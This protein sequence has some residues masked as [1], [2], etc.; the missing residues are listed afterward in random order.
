[1]KHR[2]YLPAVLITVLLLGGCAFP[3]KHAI[4][5]EAAAAVEAGDYAGALELLE[6]AEKAG[7][8]EQLLHRARALADMG[9]ADYDGAVDEF[10]RALSAN[11]GYVRRLDVD[12]SYYLAV[13][14]YRSGDVEGA[15]DTYSAIISLYPEESDAFLQRGK[16]ELKLGE[17]D[18]A[19]ADFN[20]AVSLRRDDPDLYIQIYESLNQ[21]GLKEDGSV[22]LKNA[23]ELNTKL[24][25]LQKGKL[26]Y[27]MEDYDKAKDALEAARNEGAGG[28]VTLY[29]GR[30]YEALG[31]TNYA[32][33][34]YRAYLEENPS[35]VEV[36]NQLGLCCLDMGDYNGALNA[37]NQG[38]SIPD[39]EYEQTLLY[40]QIVAYEYLTDFDQASVLMDAYLSVYPD[41]EA[42]VRESRF[43]ETR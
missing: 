24:T 30:T 8:D 37:F 5:D 40:N 33:S 29:L 19:L 1:M 10:I 21:S 7:E 6:N 25:N 17:R 23:M 31:D 35:D 18:N 16:T 39:N 20:R 3:G 14:Q 42:A 15:K 26:Y 4:T 36:C 43:L 12:S 38:L 11:S 22:Y 28:N 13:A 34:L 2:R 41:D 32:A 27:C 9:L